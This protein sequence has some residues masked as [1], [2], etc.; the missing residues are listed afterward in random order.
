MYNYI[1][2]ET[3]FCS[4]TAQAHSSCGC[5]IDGKA[6][7]DAILD[8]YRILLTIAGVECGKVFGWGNGIKHEWNIV[9]IEGQW[10]HVDVTW[11]LSSKAI[12]GKYKWFMLSE[13][14]ISK[15]H[16]HFKKTTTN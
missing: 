3:H 11:D 12:H 6:V 14:E 9:K 1:G 13:E 10:Y 4:N 16:S 15:D 2:C 5:L 8:V 7:C